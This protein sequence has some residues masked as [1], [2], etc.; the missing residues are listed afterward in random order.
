M[1]QSPILWGCQLKLRMKGVQI[2][3]DIDITAI[4]DGANVTKREN[5]VG[6]SSLNF[7]KRTRLR[8]SKHL[9]FLHRVV[10]W[11]KLKYK[12]FVPTNSIEPRRHGCQRIALPWQWI[13]TPLILLPIGVAIS[14]E[15]S[16]QCNQAFALTRPYERN[17]TRALT[18]WYKCIYTYS[19]INS[20]Q[21]SSLSRVRCGCDKIP[22]APNFHPQRT[23]ELE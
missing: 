14:V 9:K 6:D 7:S 2:P 15:F 20:T 18:S 12:I 4:W 10:K 21:R 1:Q 3:N 5:S 13:T 11:N 8:V 22:R 16:E 23:L 17:V 19:K